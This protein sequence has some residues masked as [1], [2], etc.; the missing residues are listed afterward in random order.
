MSDNPS[1]TR[2]DF[3]KLGI[4]SL[5]SV[6]FEPLERIV[7][8]PK[9]NISEIINTKH[10]KE[11]FLGSSPT[12][13]Y[14]DLETHQAISVPGNKLHLSSLVRPELIDYVPPDIDGDFVETIE[15]I[16]ERPIDGTSDLET[17]V[18]KMSMGQFV[19]IFNDG[20]KQNVKG[21][22]PDP[23]DENHKYVSISPLRNNIISISYINDRNR[24]VNGFAV[25]QKYNLYSFPEPPGSVYGPR[26]VS[27]NGQPQAQTL[28]RALNSRRLARFNALY[29]QSVEIYNKGFQ[30]INI[31][32]TYHLA[33]KDDGSVLVG[34]LPDYDLFLVTPNFT[35]VSE[36]SK[37]YKIIGIGKNGGYFK[38]TLQ[39]DPKT[40]AQLTNNKKVRLDF[41]TDFRQIMKIAGASPGPASKNVA[42]LTAHIQ[43]LNIDKTPWIVFSESLKGGINP[44]E[45][46][47]FLFDIPDDK[48]PDYQ[49]NKRT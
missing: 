42:I 12:T 11:S 31:D 37:D 32:Q 29:P 22:F 36:L 2:R 40:L 47:K 18:V 33:T 43:N 27:E 6:A 26:E 13:I 19:L 25:W 28:Y 10:W 48:T 20:K 38:S 16:K 41:I 39:S 45:E 44:P 4:L 15:W 7:D 9:N 14:E 46:Y 3:L 30:K 24:Y 17:V 35:E 49:E 21:I 34:D 1:F 23:L 8:P 5:A